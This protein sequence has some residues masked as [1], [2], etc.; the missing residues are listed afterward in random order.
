MLGLIVIRATIGN[1]MGREV[2]TG[3]AAQQMPMT[4]VTKAGPPIYEKLTIPAILAR[5]LVFS[6]AHKLVLCDNADT[7]NGPAT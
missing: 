1:F 4:L 5:K 6:L 2:S 7:G 3:T